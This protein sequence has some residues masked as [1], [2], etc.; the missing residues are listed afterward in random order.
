VFTARYA[1]SAY[2]KQLRFVLK[3]LILSLLLL[4]SFAY[5]ILCFITA[6]IFDET[7]SHEAEKLLKAS[8]KKNV[9]FDVPLDLKCQGNGE[10]ELTFGFLKLC[11]S[12]SEL[13]P[14]C[15]SVCFTFT[16]RTD[17]RL[18]VK[19]TISVTHRNTNSNRLNNWFCDEA[20]FLV[21]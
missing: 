10:K 8:E 7:S 4:T 18:A 19:L 16:T 15:G 3:G 13:F 12:F 21:V 6:V 9:V 14:F 1:L 5:L 2:I 20:G 11:F 17:H